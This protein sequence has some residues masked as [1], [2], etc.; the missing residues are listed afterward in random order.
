MGVGA[1]KVGHSSGVPLSR[2]SSIVRLLCQGGKSSGVALLY[3]I[4][5]LCNY[6][7]FPCKTF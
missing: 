2:R 1:N 5:S 3:F 6:S 7:V 4:L